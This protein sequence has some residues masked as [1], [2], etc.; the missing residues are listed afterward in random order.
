MK[1]CEL[2]EE[3]KSLSDNGIYTRGKVDWWLL[4]HELRYISLSKDFDTLKVEFPNAEIN[5][6][7]M[8]VKESQFIGLYEKLLEVSDQHRIEGNYKGKINL[9]NIINEIKN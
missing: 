7:K 8:L 3:L 1:F 2:I 9:N 6:H 4:K 5:N